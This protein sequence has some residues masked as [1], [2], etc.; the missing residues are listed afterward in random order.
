MARPTASA[1]TIMATTTITIMTT[2]TTITTMTQKTK[3]VNCL[4][5]RKLQIQTSLIMS[6][7]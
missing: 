7:K 2:A 4:L 1:R 6:Q 3:K 5:R